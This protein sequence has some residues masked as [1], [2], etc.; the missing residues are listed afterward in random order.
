MKAATINS[1]AILSSPSVEPYVEDPVLLKKAAK[2]SFIGN[3][4]EWFDYASYGYFATI[5]ASVFFAKSDPAVALMSTYGIFALSFIVRPFGGIFWGHIGDKYG[6]KLA[7]S[8][9]ILI[10]SGATFLIGFLP[11]YASVGILAPL[12]LLLLRMVQGFSASGEYAGASAFM[13]EY[14]PPNKKGFYTSIVPASTA[15]GLLLGSLIAAAMTAFMDTDFLQSYGWRIPFLLAAP[16]GLVGRYMRLNLEKTPAFKAFEESNIEKPVPIKNLF[17]NHKKT[18]CIAFML[19]SLNAV[20]FYLILSYMPTYLS[21]QMGVNETQ[22]LLSASISLAA[23][24]GMIFTMGKLSD[25]Y[26]RKTMLI[27]ASVLFIVLT[28]P[29]FHLLSTGGFLFIVLIQLVFSLLL[30]INDGTLPAFLTEIFPVEIRYSGFAF[31]FNFAN[32]LL[33]GTTPLM[34][35][36]LI[37]KTGNQGAPAWLLVGASILALVATLLYK[38]HYSKSILTTSQT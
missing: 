32:A 21:T 6:R 5:I 31:T 28:V 26:G 20:A 22:S 16:L 36:W 13:A 18:L 30:S 38:Q 12:L 35:T 3:F 10:M 4:V 29:L 2:A 24:I 33:G 15:A 1:H 37:A 7:L 9:S 14:A 11:S 25:K 8:W 23:Y 34:A 17:A 19:C 27:I